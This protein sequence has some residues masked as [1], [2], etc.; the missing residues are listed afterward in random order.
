MTEL[1]PLFPTPFLRAPGALDRALV[2]GLVDHFVSRADRDNNS[3]AHLTHTAMLKPED[4]P[5]LVQAAHAIGPLLAELGESL[6]GERLGWSLKEVWVNV[7]ETGG[8][9]ATHNHANSFISGVAYL[10]ECHPDACTVFMKPMGGA[11]FTFRHDHAGVR[12]GP[13]NASRWVS[14]QPEPGDIVLFPSGLL[15]AVPHNPGPRRITMAFNAIPTH[16]DS[17]GY[18]ITF[19][20]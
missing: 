6:L 3:S 8:H 5:L 16:M 15:H 11:D 18:R 2:N 10:T 14:P 20:G 13:F 19:G 4:S 1:I 9:Q 12:Q 17:W 7:L